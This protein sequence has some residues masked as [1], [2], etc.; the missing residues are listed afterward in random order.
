MAAGTRGR[1][2]AVC[3]HQQRGPARPPDREPSVRLAAQ[4][5][6]ALGTVL[7]AAGL[8]RRPDGT[9]RGRPAGEVPPLPPGSSYVT[10]SCG[11]RRARRARVVRTL[12]RF[13]EDLQFQVVLA[14]GSRRGADGAPWV[15]A[16]LP[17]APNG[18]RGWLRADAVDLRPVDDSLLVAWAR[19]PAARGAA[20]PRRLPAARRRRGRR[21]RLGTPTARAELLRRD[22]RSF[23]PIRLYRVVTPTSRQSAYTRVTDSPGDGVVGIARN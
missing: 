6:A 7:G 13:R 14:L 8:L 11:P 23:P 19:C 20:R 9:C 10:R 16:L 21:S 17:G 18:A 15:R 2:F 12:R 4:R 5:L 22:L 3:G 1:G